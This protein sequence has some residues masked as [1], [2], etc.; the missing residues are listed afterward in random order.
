MY[1]IPEKA[2]STGTRAQTN[3][4]NPKTETAKTYL[5]LS[6]IELNIFRNS[7]TSV[8][9]PLCSLPISPSVAISHKFNQ[10]LLS[11]A[12][13]RQIFILNTKSFLLIHCLCVFCVLCNLCFVFLANDSPLPRRKE[14]FRFFVFHLL[15]LFPVRYDDVNI[16]TILLLGRRRA[17]SGGDRTS[18]IENGA[19]L[20]RRLDAS[21]Q[22]RKN[23]CDLCRI[24]YLQTLEEPKSLFFIFH[25]WIALTVGAEIHG[26]TQVFH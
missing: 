3:T 2:Q 12:S 13:L 1:S 8:M 25:Q 19:L 18:G 26:G 14:R 21:R 9:R 7:P 24:R 16:A 23:L 5:L 22:I 20:S 17:C 6:R 4:E 10:R 11:F 15:L